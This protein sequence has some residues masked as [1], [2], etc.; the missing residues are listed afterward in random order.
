MNFRDSELVKGL[1]LEA[2]FGLADLPEDADAILFNSCSVRKHAEDRL[3]SNIADLKSLKKRN[4]KLV[5]G[6]MGC[7]AQNYGQAMFK[8]VPLLDFVCGPGDES[9]IPA[10][11]RDILKDRCPVVATGKVNDRRPETSPAY[12]EENFKA[13]VSISE[14]CGNF[15]SYC[16]VPYVRGRERSRKAAD[17]IREV[18]DLATRGF[19]E[20]ML[21]GQNVNSYTNDGRQ[22]TGDGFVRLLE[23]IDA[24]DGIE[25]IRFITSH[26]KDATTGLF[27]AMRDLD[28]VCEHLHLPMQAGSNLI[29]KRMNRG[30]TLKKYLCLVDDYRRMVPEGSITTD[31]IVGFPSETKKDFEKTARAME[32]V[33]FDGAFMFKYSSRPPAKSSKFKDDVPKDE[34]QKRLSE[35]TDLQCRISLEKNTLMVGGTL[36][37]LV[38]GK[39]DKSPGLLTGRTRT[40]KVV[41]FRG[42]DT[43]IG[44]MVN[45]KINS[46]SP[47]ALK[48]EII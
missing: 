48:G 20:I 33:R 16:I 39:N 8:M 44:K 41:V 1:L 37:A 15:C 28:K 6:L 11:V 26:P 35:L 7:T 3:I 31:I 5:I 24:I 29:L 12:R 25:R 47:H 30:Y 21:L 43:L 45:V 14:G 27:K 38:D 34:K 46:A 10:L 18:K 22:T 9:D 42:A 4:P 23:A 19:K 36:E 17:I 13:Y 40:N 32:S 2:G